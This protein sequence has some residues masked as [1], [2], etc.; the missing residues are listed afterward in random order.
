MKRLLRDILERVA[1]AKDFQYRIAD[2]HP[3]LAWAL[4]IGGTLMG[5]FALWRDPS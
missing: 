3:R 4:I 5:L 2:R 1:Y